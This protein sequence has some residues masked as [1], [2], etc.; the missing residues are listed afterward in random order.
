M[1]I[2]QAL[3]SYPPPHTGSRQLHIVHAYQDESRPATF[4]LQ[5][6]DPQL[7]HF[8]YQR[9]LENKLRQNF[10]FCGTPLQLIFTKAIQKG[11][12]K[13]EVRT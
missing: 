6:N 5:V 13:I 3:S 4:V 9:Y 10:S 8:S 12:K 11:S 2:E 1:V 7:V